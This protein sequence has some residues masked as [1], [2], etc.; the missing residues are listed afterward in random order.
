M[1][2]AADQI[3]DSARNSK[4]RALD[5]YADVVPNV[6]MEKSDLFVETKYLFFVLLWI[7]F[8]YLNVS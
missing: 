3:L 7:K 5:F 8:K 6:N 1:Q 4:S 2:R